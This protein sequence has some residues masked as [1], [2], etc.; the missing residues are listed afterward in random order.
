ML[1]PFFEHRYRV[2][3]SIVETEKHYESIKHPVV[4]EVIRKYAPELRLEIHH[5]GDLPARS[6]IGSSAAFVVGMLHS[7]LALQKID[8]DSTKLAELAIDME[9]NILK[10]NVGW[11]D[12]IACAKGGFNLINFE[13]DDS[14]NI[15]ACQISDKTRDE[16][17]ERMVLVYSGINR[18][19]SDVTAGLLENLESKKNYIER[20]VE[21]TDHALNIFESDGDLDQIGEMLEESWQLKKLSNQR[22]HNSALDVIFEK[23]K[24][25]GAMGGKVLGAGGGG[26]MLFWLQ[27]GQRDHFLKDFEVG[28]I[29]PFNIS[30]DGS[31]LIHKSV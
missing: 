3:Y 4:R 21:L 10:E 17:E 23:A 25:A 19:S 18:N 28:T 30:Y 6:G 5:D 1:P 31:T 8:V 29:V 14:W 13:S 7:I 9:F 12:Q 15:K 20:L 24:R 11:Q 16:M 26:F 22:S 27:S 2:A